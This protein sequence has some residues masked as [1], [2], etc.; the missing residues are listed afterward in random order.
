MSSSQC[1]L[2][3]QRA[4]RREDLDN[5]VKGAHDTIVENVKGFE[6]IPDGNFRAFEK[7]AELAPQLTSKTTLPANYT[8]YLANI[9]R[10][11]RKLATDK[12]FI[13][14]LTDDQI[15]AVANAVAERQKH[16]KTYIECLLADRTEGHI[17]EE[18]KRIQEEEIKDAL[19]LTLK[20][21]FTDR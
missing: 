7:I 16:I 2:T 13:A 5:A 10:R 19:N 4:P 17:T 6:S 12:G 21:M 1:E 11:T 9:K 8:Q 18:E 20:E 3:V 15:L 14:K